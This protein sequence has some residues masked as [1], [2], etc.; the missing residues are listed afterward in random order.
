MTV[1]H[2]LGLAPTAMVCAQEKNLVCAQRYMLSVCAGEVS[3]LYTRVCVVCAQEKCL[4]C[5]KRCVW[6]VCRRSVLFLHKS[7]CCVC[8][9]EVFYR[10][11]YQAAKNPSKV[12]GDRQ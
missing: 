7:V 11:S 12:I 4:V 9:G 5:E 3:C 10:W 1:P 2:T 6:C 8:A